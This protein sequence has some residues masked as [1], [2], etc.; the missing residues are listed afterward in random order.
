[1]NLYLS[2]AFLFFIGSIAGWCMELLFRHFTNPERKWINPG[3]CV[4]PYVPIYGFGLCILFLLALLEQ[5]SIISSPIWNKIVLFAAMAVCM[6]VIEYIAGILCIKVLK[7][8]LWDYTNMWG[9]IQGIICPLFSFFWAVLG[10]VYYFLLHPWMVKALKWLSNNLA[11]SFFIGVFFGVFM[12]DVVYSAQ[13]VAKIK[14][15]AEDNE[16]IVRYESLKAQIHSIRKKNRQK[17]HFFFTLRTE[18][19]LA[20]HLKEMRSSFEK[21]K[22][23]KPQKRK[24][25]GK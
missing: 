17:T 19:P 13:L 8:R 6:T 5:H 25:K 3:F 23:E 15:F 18:R 11:F 24:Q 2:L 20:E 4:G 22:L 16:V 12:I 1:M 10:A 21:Y 9:N 7:V 14:K